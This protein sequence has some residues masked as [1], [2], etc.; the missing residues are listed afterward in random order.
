MCEAIVYLEE[1]GERKKLMD[2]VLR[3]E[4]NGDYLVLSKFLEPPLTVRA[5]IREIDMH[6]HIVILTPS[7]VDAANK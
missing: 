3:I 4:R 2:N 7:D 6:K 5:A 1:N